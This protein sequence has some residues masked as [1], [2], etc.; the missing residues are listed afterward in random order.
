MRNIIFIS[1]RKEI[2]RVLPRALHNSRPVMKKMHRHPEI[3]S[4]IRLLQLLIKNEGFMILDR[5]DEPFSRHEF[6]GGEWTEDVYRFINYSSRYI[7][8]DVWLF[9]DSDEKNHYQL[10]FYDMIRKSYMLEEIDRKKVLLEFFSLDN[11]E[12]AIQTNPELL[13]NILLDLL[14][15]EELRYKEISGI[16]DTFLK[17]YIN[18]LESIGIEFVEFKSIINAINIAYYVDAKWFLE[19]ILDLLR[20]QFFGRHPRR[21]LTLVYLYPG[22]IADLIDIMPHMFSPNTFEMFFIERNFRY[23]DKEKIF[24]YIKLLRRF[25]ELA[26]GK[27]E[28]NKKVSKILHMLESMI[29]QFDRFDKFRKVK[30]GQFTLDQ[31][32][33]LR[34]YANF[35]ENQHVSLGIKKFLGHYLET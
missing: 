31:L 17:G 15:N 11:L 23:I 4:G 2:I 32:E 22:F 12:I 7:K 20:Y 35:T 6:F 28:Y 8:S 29:G 10:P 34:W 19:H 21:F 5:F 25:Y 26:K 14:N 1:I 9:Q 13:S 18:Q 30:L 33:D 3:I 24:D 27:N 16:I